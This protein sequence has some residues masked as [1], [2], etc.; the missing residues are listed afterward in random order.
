MVCQF[1]VEALACEKAPSKTW[2]LRSGEPAYPLRTDHEPG[3]HKQSPARHWSRHGSAPPFCAVV[4]VCWLPSSFC[5]PLWNRECFF[6]VLRLSSF[7][8]PFVTF[9][10][11]VDGILVREKPGTK[12]Y[13][14]SATE[15]RGMDLCDRGLPAFAP[16]HATNR[17][18]GKCE[19]FA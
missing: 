6:H 5:G 4:V 16:T 11:P 1:F 12:V 19:C 7:W 9:M 14:A 15:A 10:Q 17:V 3:P 18:S 8:K 2:L 13:V